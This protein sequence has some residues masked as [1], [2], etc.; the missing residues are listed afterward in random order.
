MI[1]LPDDL[2]T[3][4]MLQLRDILIEHTGDLPVRMVIPVAGREV[5][6]SPEQRFCVHLDQTLVDAVEKVLGRGA[7]RKL[8]GEPPVGV[9]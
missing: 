3:A 8:Y 1:Q 5:S 9:S 2:K 4:K 7:L 6:I